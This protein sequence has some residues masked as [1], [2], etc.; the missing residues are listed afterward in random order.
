MGEMK[1]GS[2]F[3][4]IGGLDLGLERAGMEIVWLVEKDPYCQKVL[5][6]HWPEV[7]C[8]GDIKEIDFATIAPVDLICGGDPCPIRSRARSNG[9]SRHAD[10]SGYFLAV[11]GVM[12]PFWVVRENVLAPDDKDFE[13]ALDLLGYRSII[14]RTDASEVTGQSRQRDFIVGSHNLSWPEFAMQLPDMQ[15]GPGPYSTR[16]GTRQVIP[17][18]TAHR[19]RYDSRDCYVWDGQLRILDAKERQAFAGVPDG[20][21]DGLSEAAISGMCG[22]AVVPQVAEWIGRIIMQ[23]D[24]GAPHV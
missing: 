11:V 5:K 20:W 4:G 10:L 17:A 22:R 13:A 12:R 7:P 3:S 8:Y 21:L 23:A 18:L 1:V 14:I 9:K 15:D 24:K 19:T 6:K 16:L 2:L